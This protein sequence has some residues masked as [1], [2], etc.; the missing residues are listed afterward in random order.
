MH[1]CD[2]INEICCE[3]QIKP[4][5]QK[6]VV[7]NCWAG[8]TKTELNCDLLQLILITKTFRISFHR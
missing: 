6:W 3:N 8:C 7:G 1:V 2:Y 5:K 4:E